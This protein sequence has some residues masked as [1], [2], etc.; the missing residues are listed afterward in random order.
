MAWS[1]A[2]VPSQQGRVC[3]ITGSNTGLGLSNARML[4]EKG[5]K[6][7]MACRN[8][9]KANAAAAGIR[10]AVPKADVH[11]SQLDLASMV[12]VRDFAKRFLA[13]HQRL[14]ILI[15]NAGVMIPPKTITM[16]GFEL[17][18]E[19][20]YL[21]H[22]LLTGLLLHTINNT[23]GARVVSL[24]SIAHRG[25]QIDFD[26]FKAERGYS[27]WGHYSQSKLACLMF[28]LELQR[29]LQKA[30]SRTL[31]LVAHPGGTATELARHIGALSVISNLIA[32][33]VD[34]GSLPTLRAAVDPNARGSEYY[35]PRWFRYFGPAVL[36][37][38]MAQA[39]DV[40]VAAKLW[41]VSEKLAGIAY[42]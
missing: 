4:A 31:S 40:D 22:F 17:Q 19:A 3:I 29:R 25:G 16:D 7:I 24:S 23:A 13:E 20:N 15:N 27:R 21:G 36:E 5:A 6:V 14:D 41:S 10:T 2:D 35:G 42:P 1:L 33:S 26:S 12:S 32:Q 9:D 18:F 28:A 11:V 30:G 8:L 39:L 38:P 37:T 34:A